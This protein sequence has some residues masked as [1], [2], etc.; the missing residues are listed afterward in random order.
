MEQK[1]IFAFV[2]MP[3]NQRFQDVY[4]IGIKEAASQ[5]GIVANRLDEQVFVEGMLERIYRQIEAADIIVADMSEQNPNV[6]YEVGYAHAKDKLCIL[7]TNEAKDIPFD[8]KHRRHIEYKGSLSFLR[9]ELTKNLEWAKSEIENRRESQIRVEI[10]TPF[11]DL[12]TNA[13]LATAIVFFRVDIFNDSNKL[14]SEINSIYLYTGNE[15]TVKQDEKDCPNI[16][17]DVLGFKH[18][19]FLVPPISRLSGNSWAQ[20]QFSAQRVIA[21][22][23]EGDEIANSYTVSGNVLLRVNTTEGTFDHKHYINV[24]VAEITF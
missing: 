10:N 4:E 24:N 14:S 12:S 9:Q 20:L 17:S 22:K 8:L 21:S 13:Y 18:R 3:F 19:Y 6:F 5:V 16:E 7:L 1:P 15:W 23:F 11:G 2:L